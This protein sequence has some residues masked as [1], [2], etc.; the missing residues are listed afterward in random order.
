MTGHAAGLPASTAT[1]H[2]RRSERCAQSQ[3]HLQSWWALAV[4]LV[5]VAASAV[6]MG[7]GHWRRGAMVFAASV[8]MA[9]VLRAVLPD[10]LAGLLAVR[11][12][13]ADSALLLGLGTVMVVVILTR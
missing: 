4:C 3:E 11:G 7:I 9:G 5:G 1:R 10:Q 12:R 6:I 13:W 8:L 2:A